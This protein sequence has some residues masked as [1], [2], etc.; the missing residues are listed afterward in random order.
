MTNSL[1]ICGKSVWLTHGHR[2]HAKARTDELA[3]WGRQYG[4]DVIIYGH[5]HVADIT[6]R[7]GLLIFNP[8]STVHPRGAG[9]KSFGILVIENGKIDAEILSPE[10]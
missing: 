4:V 6:W 5:S 8:G 1:S 10:P 3:W 2:Y 7:D 9:P